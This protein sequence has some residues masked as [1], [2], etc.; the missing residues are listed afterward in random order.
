MELPQEGCFI[1]Q[2]KPQPLEMMWHSWKPCNVMKHSTT[3]ILTAKGDSFIGST[4]SFPRICWT[5]L[6]TSNELM[7]TTQFF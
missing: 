5:V 1:H 7:W 3:Y 6:V 2:P 4:T